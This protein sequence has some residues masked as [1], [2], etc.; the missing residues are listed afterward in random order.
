[1]GQNWST[2]SVSRARKGSKG[3]GG[4]DRQNG[5]GEPKENGKVIS[6][7]F[8]P[9][10]SANGKEVKEPWTSSTP[11]TRLPKTTPLGDAEKIEEKTKEDKEEAEEEMGET[12]KEHAKALMNGELP[13]ELRQ[14]LVKSSP[15]RHSQK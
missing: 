15:R 9:F 5:K 13:T 8:Q 1:M 11:T 6:E 12:M 14:A 2:R 3:K 7:A 10:T 4:K